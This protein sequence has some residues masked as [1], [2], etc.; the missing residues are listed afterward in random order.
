MYN[1]KKA[2]RRLDFAPK[3]ND[4]KVTDIKTI[5]FVNSP[6]RDIS[7]S[8]GIQFAVSILYNSEVGVS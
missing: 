8:V 6:N 5:G 7:A 2:V 3:L 4:I 1:I